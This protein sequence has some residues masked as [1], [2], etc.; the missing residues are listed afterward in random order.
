MVNSEGMKFM[1]GLD[2][3]SLIKPVLHAKGSAL[4]VVGGI[5]LFIYL[6]TIVEN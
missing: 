5:S 4:D 2:F 3:V 1:T 6:A